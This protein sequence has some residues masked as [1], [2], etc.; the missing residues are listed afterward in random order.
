MRGR[1][2]SADRRGEGFVEH[3]GYSFLFGKLEVLSNLALFSS[4]PKVYSVSHQI[5]DMQ[6]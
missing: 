3:S 4:Y 1:E 6:H 2:G 5:F